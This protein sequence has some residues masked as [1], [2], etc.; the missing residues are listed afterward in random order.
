MKMVLDN[1]GYGFKLISYGIDALIRKKTERGLSHI[2]TEEYIKDNIDEIWFRCD[3]D[4][5][6]ILEKFGLGA[7]LNYF[8]IFEIPD[9]SILEVDIFTDSRIEIEEGEYG[10][11]RLVFDLSK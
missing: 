10:F 2:W 5:I 3:E 11:E 9:L 8:K 6:E 4:L 1:S 7:S